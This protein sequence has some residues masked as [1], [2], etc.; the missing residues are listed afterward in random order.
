MIFFSRVRRFLSSLG[1]DPGRM[2][3]ALL[4]VPG[5][6]RDCRR[7]RQ[8]NRGRPD[9]F[10][11]FMLRPCW[12]DRKEGSGVASG[13]YFHQDLLVARR[14][15]ASNP[16]RH[17]D[18]GSRVDGFVA[19]VASFRELY[20]L[21]VRPLRPPVSGVCFRQADLMNPLDPSLVG[22]CDS[23]SSLHAVEHFGLGRYGDPIRPEGYRVGLHNMAR[24]LEPGG[25][26]YLSVPMGPPRIEFNAHRVFGLKDLLALLRPDFNSLCF[27]YVDDD[28]HLHTNV[29]LKDGEVENNFNCWYGLAIL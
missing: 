14:I 9:L 26:F 2:W 18:V 5:Y 4:G 16:R 20:L 1:F 17:V 21:D 28:G 6:V 25:T 22:F 7:F 24:I 11:R 27:S 29:P 3:C 12:K 10:P 15:F 8:L 23:L 13:H 19:H